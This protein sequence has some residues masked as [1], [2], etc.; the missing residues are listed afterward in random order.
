MVGVGGGGGGGGGGKGVGVSG[1]VMRK[2]H[3]DNA[4]LM[5]IR[6]ND[7]LQQ[8]INFLQHTQKADRRRKEL[9]QKLIWQKYGYLFKVPAYTDSHLRRSAINKFRRND[10]KRQYAKDT[11]IYSNLVSSNKSLF[12]SLHS[13]NSCPGPLPS[14]DPIASSSNNN[15]DSNTQ[16]TAA[17]KKTLLAPEERSC[18]SCHDTIWEKV[19]VGSAKHRHYAMLQ[20][21]R[22]DAML[23]GLKCKQEQLQRQ[24]TDYFRRISTLIPGGDTSVKSKSKINSLGDLLFLL[25]YK[26]HE[27]KASLEKRDEWQARSTQPGVHERNTKLRWKKAVKTIKVDSYN[28]GKSEIRE[29]LRG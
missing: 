10:E 7:R 3:E 16:K 18:Y 22:Q 1:G 19:L 2:N 5:N 12:D 15:Q 28:I 26:L 6:E 11:Q 25:N 14:S 21:K 24:Q 8:Q 13:I 17:Y 9:D 29:F 23:Q 4:I 20:K 27:E